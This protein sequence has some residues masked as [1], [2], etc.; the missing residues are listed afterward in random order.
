MKKLFI[1][2]LAATISACSAR[3]ATQIATQKDYVQPEWYQQCKDIDTES[4]SMAFWDSKLYYYSC[5][6]GVSGYESA[7]HIKSL[8]I[9]KRNMADRLMGEISSGTKIRIDDIG[10]P[11]NMQT[12][13]ETTM[14]I[15]NKIHDTTLRHYAQTEHF[16]YK[17]DGLFHS[18][19]MIKLNKEDVDAM[20]DL[21]VA[22]QAQ[23]NVTMPERQLT[24]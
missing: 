15:V 11:S 6:S 21:A 13:T 7:A 14:L 22:K 1:I 9:A 10:T 20:I 2:A 19:V 16:V 3:N 24:N 8:Q 23:K 5:G 17:M 12:E 4:E 18:F